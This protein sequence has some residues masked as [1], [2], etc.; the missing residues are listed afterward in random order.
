M[1]EHNTHGPTLVSVPWAYGISPSNHVE[2]ESHVY[3]KEYVTLEMAIGRSQSLWT[4]ELCCGRRG[5]RGLHI[6][7]F[8]V[9][10]AHTV[11]EIPE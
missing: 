8:R 4:I 3:R 11:A 2:G 5:R 1:G 6:A 10:T 9:N 7:K